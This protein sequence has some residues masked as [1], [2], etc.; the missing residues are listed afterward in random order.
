[1]NRINRR[2]SANDDMRTFVKTFREH[3]QNVGAAYDDETL[4]RLLRRLQILIFDFTATGSASEQ[5][6]KERAVRALHPDDTPR[7]GE[8]WKVA[9][10]DNRL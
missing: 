7:A 3:L 10:G 8:L 6:A 5:L 9:S 2:G 1:V 4:W